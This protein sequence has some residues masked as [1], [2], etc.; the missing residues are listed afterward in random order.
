MKASEDQGV[1]SAFG[2]LLRDA[3]RRLLSMGQELVHA[4]ARC[5]SLLR[6]KIGLPPQG[7][8]GKHAEGLDHMALRHLDT[9][10]HA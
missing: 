3:A 4:E 5:G 8:L 1:S 10:C 2:I 9:T 6:V 7:A